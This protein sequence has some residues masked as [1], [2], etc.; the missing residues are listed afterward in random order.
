VARDADVDAYL[1]WTHGRMV[2]TSTQL[3]DVAR[4]LERWYDVRV[5]VSP[6]LERRRL[7]MSVADA[8]LAEVLNAI[9][10]ALNVRHQVKGGVVTISPSPEGP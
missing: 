7:T 1:G 4:T 8:S 2:F 6:A 10:I 3:G 5:E 9:S